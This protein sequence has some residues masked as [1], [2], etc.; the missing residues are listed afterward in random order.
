MKRITLSYL[1]AY[2]LFGGLGLAFMP[3]LT[4]DLFQSNGD[5]GDIMPRLVGTFMIAL[6]GLIGQFVYLRD[7]KYYPYSVFIR[8]FIVIFLFFLY[9]RS[10]DPLFL[11]LNV[12]VLI[13]LVPSI[14]TLIREWM[15]STQ[16][17]GE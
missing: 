16:S 11:V 17:G 12:I 2:L 4:L 6:G 8:T 13:G 3:Q 15:G 7:Y 1:A 5:Y 14:Y 9:V 10:D